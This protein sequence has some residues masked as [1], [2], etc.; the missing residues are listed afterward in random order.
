M[1]YRPLSNTGI[2]VSEVALGCWPIAGITSPGVND[3]DSLATIQACFDLGINHLDTAY[4][5]GRARRERAADRP[6]PRPAA[7]TRW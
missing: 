1:N 4:C 5:Y 7:A 2:R 3:A 6:G